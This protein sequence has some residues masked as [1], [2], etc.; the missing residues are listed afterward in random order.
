MDATGSTAPATN[1]PDARAF[2]RIID[3]GFG[4]QAWHGPEMKAAISDVTPERAFWRP[5]PGRHNIAEITLHHAFWIHRI[6]EQIAGSSEPFVMP[7]EDWFA[8]ADASVKSW[9]DVVAALQ[10]EQSLLVALG[11]GLA[12]GRISSPLS[13]SDRFDRILGITCHAA[14]HAGQ[15]QLIKALRSA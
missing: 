13:E 8:L 3:E 4:R 12:A 10:S 6:R 2:P 5:A 15:I 9:P 11:A 7:G 1:L 14:Y